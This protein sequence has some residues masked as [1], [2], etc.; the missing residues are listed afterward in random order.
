MGEYL[1]DCAH[2]HTIMQMLRKHK[3]STCMVQTSSLMLLLVIGSVV[4]IPLLYVFSSSLTHSLTQIV[5]IVL[6][7]SRLQQV[8]DVFGQ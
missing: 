3:L 8:T 5:E 4:A 6:L 2:N 7:D 1:H